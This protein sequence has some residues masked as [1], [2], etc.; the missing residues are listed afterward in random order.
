MELEIA[1]KNTGHASLY[2]IFNI[3]DAANAPNVLAF[4]RE[5]T[6]TT[7]KTKFSNPERAQTSFKSTDSL[8]GTWK[9]LLLDAIYFLRIN[10]YRENHFFE[11]IERINKTKMRSEG[12]PESISSN[13]YGIEELVEYF[14]Q[15]SDFESTL[16]GADKYYR[17]HIV[18]PLNVWFIGL[19]IIKEYGKCFKLRVMNEIS[20]EDCDCAKREW[21]ETKI[22]L[23]KDKGQ[24]A[25][26]GDKPGEKELPTESGGC[27]LSLAELAAMWTVV[28]LTHDLGYPLEKVEKVNEKLEKMLSKFGKIGFSRFRFNFEIQH[29]HLVRFLLNLISALAKPLRKP[30]KENEYDFTKW[31][32]HIRTKYYSKFSKSWEMFD[33]G[34]VSSLLLLKSL[35]FFIESDFCSEHNEPLSREDARQF[36]IRSEILHA[37]ASHTTAKIYHLSPDNLP[38]LLILCDDLQEWSRPT[39]GDMKIGI[40][41]DAVSVQLQKFEINEGGSSIHCLINYPECDYDDQQ[42]HAIRVFKVWLERFRPAL[43]DKERSIDFFWEIQFGN[44]TA[45]SFRLDTSQ[46]KIFKT[47]IYKRPNKGTGIS[48]DFDLHKVEEE[49]KENKK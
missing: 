26:D 38:F 43:D 17:D 47:F 7:L 20:V 46:R 41:G 40:K 28:A 36:A 27:R 32:T 19:H 6:L 12:V 42:E 9:T 11:D 30:D 1:S 5:N 10:D 39:L 13:V 24:A 14:A 4:L 45:W 3:N 48:E 22:A 37:M 31:R 21:F 49:M 18:H 23:Q 29:D 8:R 35:T 34:I 2:N 25:P 16:Y 33:H 44:D 15:F